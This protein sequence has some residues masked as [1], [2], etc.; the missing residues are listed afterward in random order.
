MQPATIVW[1]SSLSGAA[2]GFVGAVAV[3]YVRGR[4]A[5]KRETTDRVARFQVETLT[6]LQEGARALI[7]ALLDFRSEMH[8]TDR[9]TSSLGELGPKDDAEFE[10][11]S[12]LEALEKLGD[13]TQSTAELMGL[14][15]KFDARIAAMEEVTRAANDETAA[16]EATFLASVE[17]DTLASRVLNPEVATRAKALCTIALDAIGA[18]RA[19]AAD[20]REDYFGPAQRLFLELQDLTGREI[21]Q[22]LQG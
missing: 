15:R 10:E 14:R 6:H 5:G 2:V 12:R 17:L 7:L 18:G 22:R 21:L 16:N 4:S 11:L 19:K 8:E 1:L 20:V 9:A 3:E 13:L